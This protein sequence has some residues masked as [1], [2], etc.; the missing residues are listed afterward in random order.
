MNAFDLTCAILASAAY[1]QDVSIKN[2]IDP[3]P[4]ATILPGPL[5]YK[6][7]GGISGFEASAF[8]YG[9]KIVI[10]YAGTN[11]EQLADLAADGALA[12]GIN[13]PQL[14]Q[15]AEFFLAI[16]N[17]PAYAG[18]EIVFTGHSLG[19]GLAAAM[20][21][22]FNKHAVTFDPAPFRLAVSQVNA[23][24]IKA[25]LASAHPSWQIGD[26]ATYSTVEGVVGLHA[27]TLSALITGLLLPINAA[28]ARTIPTLDFPITIRGEGNIKAY[29]VSGEFLTNGIQ[30][31]ASSDLNTLR[32]QSTS[33]PESIN[34]NPTG[35]KIGLF[36]L[37]SMNL[38]IV[39]AQEPRLATLFNLNP[40]IAE[41]LFDK[42]LYAHKG[43]DATVDLLARLVQQEF[44]TASSTTGTGLLAKF[45]NDLTLLTANTDGISAQPSIQKALAVV[46]MEYYYFKDTASATALLSSIGNA[47]HF[48][49]SDIP[50]TFLKSQ[51]MLVTAVRSYLNTDEMRALGM[52]T[53]TNQ[54]AT[55]GTGYLMQQNAWHIQSGTSGM[56]WTASGSTN[57]AVI[58]GAQTDI[59]DAGA[60]NDI[61]IGGAGRDFI[62]GGAGND[63]LLGGLDVDTY[64]FSA[65]WGKDTITDSDGL[66]SIQLDGTP[67]GTAQGVGERNQWAFDLGG[68]QYAGITVIANSSSSTGYSATITR[69]TDTANTITIQ[70]FDFNA[71]RS[72]SDNGYL[73][74]KLDT[75]QH[76]ALIQGDGTAVGASTANVYADISFED[77]QL[78]GHS[79]SMNER[80]GKPF[81][82]YLAQAAQEGDTLTLA[83]GGGLADASYERYALNSCLRHI[84]LGCRLIKHKNKFCQRAKRIRLRTTISCSEVRV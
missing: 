5:G 46:A 42:T 81:H 73:G 70:N 7:I 39:A 80:G 29:S 54:F 28:L 4:G 68:G 57:D 37:H 59:I 50:T 21:V 76:V 79:S 66:G 51:S 52:S 49:Y 65:G 22:F 40:R 56:N 15:A 24:A 82:I 38:L 1:Q 30:G 72:T 61:V 41:A 16:Q 23:D 78:D 43:S 25:S 12:L 17:N 47:I 18:R 75:T 34:I 67:L 26:L 60:G 35:A 45:A 27:P 48:D 10:S 62:N 53:D 13:H 14:L 2:R 77:A 6:T 71:A 74:I 3:A 11:T 44:S 36:D 33:Q 84:S 20:G 31:F 64:T 19:G 8:D 63:R 32:I 55:Q 9:G 83:A 58:G 69:G